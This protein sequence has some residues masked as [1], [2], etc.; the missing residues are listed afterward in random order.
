MLTLGCLSRS[1]E[2]MHILVKILFTWQGNGDSH[3]VPIQWGSDG[4]EGPQIRLQN[5]N[6][7]T[8]YHTVM[9]PDAVV[10]SPP[11]QLKWMAKN[12]HIYASQGNQSGLAVAWW[13]SIQAE[14]FKDSTHTVGGAEEQVKRFFSTTGSIYFK[15]T[16]LKPVDCSFHNG[17]FL[18]LEAVTA[19]ALSTILFLKC[20]YGACRWLG[21]RG[22]LCRSCTLAMCSLWVAL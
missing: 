15:L 13:I 3:N 14:A 12:W 9:I 1:S 21:R 4:G 17:V 19:A 2:G 7:F 18:L 8:S 11:P 10:K 22:S 5:S 20:L 16:K 6:H